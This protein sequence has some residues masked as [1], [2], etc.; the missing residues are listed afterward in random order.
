MLGLLLVVG[1]TVLGLVLV[2]VA[3]GEPVHVSVAPLG[4]W[5]N[6]GGLPPKAWLIAL[7]TL[8]WVAGSLRVA[9]RRA[10]RARDARRLEE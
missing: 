3:R 6:P 5:V 2:A 8:A 9:Q 7:G 10:C 1:G 4:T